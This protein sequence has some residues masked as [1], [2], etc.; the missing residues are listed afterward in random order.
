MKLRHHLEDE[1]LFSLRNMFFRNQRE[2]SE[3]YHE[4]SY[5]R[6]SHVVRTTVVACEYGV[7]AVVGV[8]RATERITTGQ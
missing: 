7:P 5:V 4:Q 1:M 3:S 8:A 6:V 2:W